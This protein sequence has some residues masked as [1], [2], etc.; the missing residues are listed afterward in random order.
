MTPLIL[1]F[2]F[3]KRN[4]IVKEGPSKVNTLNLTRLQF[5][6]FSQFPKTKEK[7]REN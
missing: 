1:N 3:N 7:E 5:Y 4:K 6:P 2:L